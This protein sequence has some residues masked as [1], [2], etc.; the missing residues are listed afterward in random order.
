MT[1]AQGLCF[2]RGASLDDAHADRLLNSELDLAAI[3]GNQTT[4]GAIMARRRSTEHEAAERSARQFSAPAASDLWVE[5]QARI[6]EQFDEVARRWLDRRREAL[7][8][9]RQSLEEMR[10]TD[11]VGELMRVQQQWVFGSL[12]RLAA[13]MSEL[14]TAAFTLTQAA[15]SQVSKTVERTGGDA[16]RTGHEMMSVA[17]SKPSFSA[18]E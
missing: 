9:T 10:S 18:V 17:G 7:D 13:D 16:E 5:S 4:E 14:G 3:V 6:F 8:A 12:Q 11:N 2:A 15:A 1:R